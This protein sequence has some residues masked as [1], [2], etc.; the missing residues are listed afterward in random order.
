MP[1][2]NNS[3]LLAVTAGSSQIIVRGKN[4]PSLCWVLQWVIMKDE[5]CM[6]R[7]CL[8]DGIGLS[9]LAIATIAFAILYAMHDTSSIIMP[10]LKTVSIQ[11]L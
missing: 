3:K 11:V 9:F 10:V 6:C 4:D 2:P 1:Q 8:V 7:D 5:Q